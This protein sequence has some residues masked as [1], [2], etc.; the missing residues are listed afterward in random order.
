MDAIMNFRVYRFTRVLPVLA[1]TILLYKITKDSGS[2][3]MTIVWECLTIN[4]ST[5]SVLAGKTMSVKLDLEILTR[6][7]TMPTCSITAAWMLHRIALDIR[8]RL[9]E[10]LLLPLLQLCSEPTASRLRHRPQA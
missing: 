3:S 4:N 6:S 5:K 9:M 2:N 1:T 10:R 8:Q 7:L